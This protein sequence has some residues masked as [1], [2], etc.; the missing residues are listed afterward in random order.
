MSQGHEPDSLTFTKRFTAT[1][2]FWIRPCVKPAPTHVY[3]I[4]TNDL[5]QV[6]RQAF[7]HIKKGIPA[8]FLRIYCF[9]ESILSGWTNVLCLSPEMER[10]QER[11]T[12]FLWPMETIPPLG[13]KGLHPYQPIKEPPLPHRLREAKVCRAIWKYYDCVRKAFSHFD[14]HS[15]LHKE[16]LSVLYKW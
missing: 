7:G 12:A 5:N 6:P 3:P 9:Y 4:T 1:D 14:R 16:A 11:R 8:M 2:C 15:L 10:V 13:A